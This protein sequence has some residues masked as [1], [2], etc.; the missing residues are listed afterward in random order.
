MEGERMKRHYTLGA[1]V[2][3]LRS[4][5]SLDERLEDAGVDP[6]SLLVLSRRRD[7]SLV[8]VSLPEANTRAVETTLRRIQWFEFGSVYLGVTAVSVLMGAVHL[9]TGIVV[10]TVMTLAAIIGLV[11]FHRLPHLKNK[12]IGLGLPDELAEK[13]EKSFPSGFALALVTVPEDLFDDAQAAFLEDESLIEPLA[14]DR[15]VVL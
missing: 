8:K 11:I 14:V 1:V 2:P 9:P 7:E 13:W 3:D 15:R 10:Q 5:D 4:L 6:S 12:V